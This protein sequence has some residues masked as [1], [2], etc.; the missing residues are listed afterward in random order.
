MSRPLALAA[1][2]FSFSLSA[3]ADP[4]LEMMRGLSKDGPIYAYEMSYSDTDVTANGLI[5]PSKPEGERIEIYAPAE[6]EWSKEFRDGI[7]DM[8]AETDGDIWCADFAQMVPTDAT[9]TSEDDS[10]VTY[11]FT[12]TPEADADKNEK[13]MMKQ[14]NGTVTLD[15]SDGSV[16]AFNMVLPKPYK[17]AM[18]AKIN[19]FEM[20]ASCDRAPD[21]RTYVEQFSMDIKGSAMMQSFE[22]TVTRRITKLL[23]P[24]G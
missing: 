16:L 8:E 9:A 11:A 1:F 5:D 2:A 10:T 12:P 23:D 18:V 4:V 14:L 22:E 7:A 19:R 15:K 21:G 3:A 13:K 6:S 24:V 20:T 17:P